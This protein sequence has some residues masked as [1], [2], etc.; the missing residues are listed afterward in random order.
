MI[1]NISSETLISSLKGPLQPYIVARLYQQ[2]VPIGAYKPR[3]LLGAQH[4][5]PAQAVQILTDLRAERGLAIHWGTYPLTTNW[6]MPSPN[7][8]LQ[9]DSYG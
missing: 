9:R 3:C 6:C 7:K 8:A 2:E 5:D 1:C 4:C